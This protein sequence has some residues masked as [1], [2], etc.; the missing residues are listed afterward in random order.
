MVVIICKHRKSWD[1]DY[2]RGCSGKFPIVYM[3]Q[4]L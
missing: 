2:T 3:W 1:Q 4:K